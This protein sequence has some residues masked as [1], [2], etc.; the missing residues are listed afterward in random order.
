VSS[1][2]DSD[3]FDPAAS[4]FAA[5]DGADDN[6]DGIGADQPA[7]DADQSQV[8]D[9]RA[10][11]SPSANPTQSP[12]ATAQMVVPLTHATPEAAVA[13]KSADGGVPSWVWI[14]VA[15]V[16]GVGGGVVVLRVQAKRARS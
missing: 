8:T 10:P 13:P 3:A 11:S 14:V 15:A 4:D 6:A 5:D 12:S 9:S 1:T 2:D 16:A 7:D